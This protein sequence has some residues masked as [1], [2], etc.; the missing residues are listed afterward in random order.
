MKKLFAV[1]IV[2]AFVIF[3]VMP[4]AAEVVSKFEGMNISISGKVKF[5][6]AYETNDLTFRGGTPANIADDDDLNWNAGADLDFRWKMGDISA[7]IKFDENGGFKGYNCTYNWGSFTTLIGK[8]AVITKAFVIPGGPGGIKI[9]NYDGYNAK[10]QDQLRVTI[11][12]GAVTLSLAGITGSN[13]QATVTTAAA[14]DTDTSQ[15][16]LEARLDFA[17]GPIQGA[18]WG[19]QYSY[20]SVIPATE[21]GYD[22]DC[23]SFGFAA[24]AA[25]GPLSFAG[26]I[27]QDTNGYSAGYADNAGYPVYIAATDTIMDF[28]KTG[29]A[30]NIGYKINNTFNVGAS[31][32]TVDTEADNVALLAAGTTYKD[33][34]D[35]YSV[36]M[37][38]NI[39]P[40]MGAAMA[41]NKKDYG[42]R[43]DVPVGS[44]AVQEGEQS[45]FKF[46]WWIAF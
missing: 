28:E 15:P 24:K 46:D 35:E 25:F 37:N 16:A 23:S 40:N 36:Y 17:V 2:A 19:G 44:A 21:K 30:A 1:L 13:H 12:M 18:F 11:P 5:N 3:T 6:P 27:W 10:D 26:T 22:I 45:A 42:D 39:S 41:Y 8:D 33:E 32:G 43:L 14:T 38:I 20:E 31:Y 29:W 7:V 4:S 9:G 34:G